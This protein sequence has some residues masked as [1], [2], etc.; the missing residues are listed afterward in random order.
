MPIIWSKT[1]SPHGNTHSRALVQQNCA[2]VVQL[3]GVLCKFILTLAIKQQTLLGQESIILE[4]IKCF[5][6]M[7]VV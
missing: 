3:Q 6:E 4:L 2:A 5:Q 1:S 7:C